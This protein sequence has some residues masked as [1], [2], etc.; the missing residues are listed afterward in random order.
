MRNKLII[1]TALTVTL[2]TGT[3]CLA[4]APTAGAAGSTAS[5]SAAAEGTGSVTSQ[6][7]IIGDQTLNLDQ[8]LGYIEK[9]NIQIKSKDQ[10][11]LLYQ[12]QYDRDSMNATLI[13]DSDTSEVNYPRGQYVNI[14]L[15]TDVIPKVDDQNIKDAKHDREDSLQN[16]KFTVE[17]QYMSAL[18]C[19]DQI[20]TIDAQIENVDQQIEQTKEKIEQGVLTSDALESLNV[21]KSQ[22][23]AS[24]NTPESQLQ[25]NLLS[26]KQAINMDLD[27][28]LT[29][30][31]AQKEY[32][33]FDDGNIANRIES[34]VKNDYDI[35]KINNNLAILNIKEDIYKQYSYNDA[36]GEVST[37]L[38]IQDLQNSLA[39]T[40]LNLKLGLWNDYYNLKNLEDN[41]A[42]ENAKVA[43]A[44]ANYD[45]I[46]S[47]VKL[48]TEVQLQ[49]DSAKLALDSELVNL[50]N[51]QNDYM[52]AVQ[53]F[54]YNLEN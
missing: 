41:V 12:R 30:T 52:E 35:G 32:K 31:P 49:A 11:I 34:A 46:L 5:I 20:N 37:G 9:N 43:S 36:T 50:K 8:V 33:K 25:Q 44:Q 22:F 39:D 29:L 13:K 16:M 18:T 26:I 45:T 24:L 3:V 28:E 54:Q 1:F 21:Q 6:Y 48:G 7:S 38:S 14:K 2:S 51:A 4:A 27:S 17:K 40:E 53:Q 23:Q 15:Q 10:K 19:Q 42:V 47:K